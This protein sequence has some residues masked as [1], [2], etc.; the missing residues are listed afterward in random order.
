MTKKTDGRVNNGKHPN[1]QANR[2]AKGNSGKAISIKVDWDDAALLCSVHCTMKEVADQFNIAQ[3]SLEE[4]CRRDQGV[5]WAEFY[6]RYQSKGKISLRR[7]M[8]HK[9]LGMAGVPLRDTNGVILRDV[10]GQV[11]WEVAPVAIDTGMA[12]FLS[13]NVLG[14]TDKVEQTG[15]QEIIIKEVEVRLSDT[16]AG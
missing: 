10:K 16:H 4:H 12:I 15:K 13:K 1:S 8:W 2:F 14:M 11:Q 5:S 6:E 9:A 7:A 3:S